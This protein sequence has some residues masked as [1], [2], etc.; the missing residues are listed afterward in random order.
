MHFTPIWIITF[1][2]FLVSVLTIVF[3]AKFATKPV[4]SYGFSFKRVFPFEVIN[5]EQNSLPYRILLCV[6]VAASFAPLFNLFQSY[7]Q[8]ENIQGLS[9]AICCIYG[10]AAIC[11]AFLHYFDAT[12]TLAHLILFVLFLCLTLLGNA[13]AAVKGFAVYDTYA[14]HDQ[15]MYSA[16]VGGIISGVMAICGVILSINPKLK[17]WAYLTKTDTGIE[18]PKVFV[19]A[20]S[21]WLSFFML[22]IGEAAYFFVLLIQ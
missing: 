2:V 19:L 9:I 4:D 14:K 21:E 12:H 18:R 22:A 10:L 13:L 20:Y 5:R 8:I 17:N 16:L 6:F 11:F 7:G 3:L 15:K 1:C